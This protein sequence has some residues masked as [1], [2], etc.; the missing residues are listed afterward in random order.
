MN[1]TVKATLN[2]IDKVLSGKDQTAAVEL[3]A[4]LSALRGPD[5]DRGYGAK[6]ATTSVIRATAFPKADKKYHTAGLEIPA[7]FRRDDFGA[8]EDRVNNKNI[9][10]K[11]I[12]FKQHAE[13]AFEALGLSW[14]TLNVPKEK[15]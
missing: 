8:V 2:V 9:F 6:K 3:W 1:K 7:S 11:S 13:A 4:V 15:K 10:S 12:H 5:F 14:D